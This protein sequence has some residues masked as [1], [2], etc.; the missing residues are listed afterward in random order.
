MNIS[1]YFSLA[2]LVL[3]I[4]LSLIV[5]SKKKT[6]FEMK[7]LKILIVSN[8]FSLTLEVMGFFLANTQTQ[9][10]LMSD[11]AMRLML[12]NSAFWMTIFYVLTYNISKPK[13]KQNIIS[14]GT[15]PIYVVSFIVIVLS[16]VLPMYAQIRD[17]IIINSYGPAVSMIF[18][19]AIFI[20]CV[21]LIS[22][23]AGIKKVK[24]KN[25]AFLFALISLGALSFTIQS[26]YPE[27]LL[28]TTVCNIT[29][30]ITY[31]TLKNKGAK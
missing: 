3:C 13:R 29:N 4:I 24:A 5:F 27:V 31:F 19:H 6:S 9:N 2:S 18:A 26:T 14:I 11:I 12:V 28:T 22:M 8:A 25:Y 20:Y 10:E 16:F 21:S 1:L 15:L 30:Y 7:M 23:F 17:G